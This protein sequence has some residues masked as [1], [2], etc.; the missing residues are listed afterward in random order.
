MKVWPNL[1]SSMENLMDNEVVNVKYY[2]RF[3]QLLNN[4]KTNFKILETINPTDF[5]YYNDYVFDTKEDAVTWINQI[6]ISQIKLVNIITRKI[7]KE[8]YKDE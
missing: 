3:D 5:D 2:V 1:I 8:L 6:I 7:P 4:F